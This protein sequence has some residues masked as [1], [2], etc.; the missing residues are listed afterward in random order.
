M[1]KNNKFIVTLFSI[2]LGLVVGAI[3]LFIS[4]YNPIEA[5]QVMFMGIFGS[6]KYISY[7]IVRS[8][9]IIITGISVAFA[10]KTGLFNIGAEGQFIIGSIFAMIA[11]YLFKLPPVIHGLVAILVGALAAGIWAGIVGVLKSKFGINEVISSIML[12]WIALYMNNYFLTFPLLRRPNS[13]ASFKVL[14]TAKINFLGQWKVSEAGKAFLKDN[15]FLRELLNPP[16][17]YGFLIAILLA[18]LVWYILKHTTLGYQL[19]AVGYNKDAAEYGGINIKKNIVVSMMIAGAISGIAGATQVLGVEHQIG[20]LAASQGYGFNGMAVSLIAG[21]NPLATI[22]AG[23]LFGGLTYGGGKLNSLIGAPSE[24]INIA[25]GSIVFFVAMP[26]LFE[27][28]G[29]IF[30]RRKRGENLD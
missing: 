3:I 15:K 21:N 18:I 26:K 29:K 12:N 6:P 1:K 7:T 24:V 5:Y 13:D 10:F 20:I 23:L 16:V 14:D 27:M 11:G 8:T 22:P 25:I 2:F 4:G 30:T 19:K 9:P 28:F 17:N